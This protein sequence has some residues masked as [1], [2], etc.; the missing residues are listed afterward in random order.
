MGILHPNILVLQYFILTI[1]Y[2][3]PNSLE[4]YQNRWYLL[5]LSIEILIYMHMFDNGIK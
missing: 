2:R 1:A 5:I 3:M 4:S